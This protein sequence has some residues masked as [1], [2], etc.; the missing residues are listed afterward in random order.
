MDN[1]ECIKRYQR[2]V[3]TA[4]KFTGSDWNTAQL[5]TITYSKK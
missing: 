5:P 2:A 4:P 1:T 3:A